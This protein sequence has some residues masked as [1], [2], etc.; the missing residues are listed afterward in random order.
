MRFTFKYTTKLLNKNSKIH[1][2]KRAKYQIII[3]YKLICWNTVSSKTSN[4]FNNTFLGI[5]EKLIFS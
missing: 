3:S 1:L 4:G 5:K 2:E